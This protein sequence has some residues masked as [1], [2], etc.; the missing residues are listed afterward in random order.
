MASSDKLLV[1]LEDGVKRITFNRPERRN[2]VDTETVG[3]LH[4]AIQ[5]SA[6]DESKVVI[7]TGAGESFC[8]GADLKAIAAGRSNRTEADGNGPMGP[9]RMLLKKPVIAAVAGY[10]VAGGLELG[11]AFTELN[12]P[13]D[14]FQ[15]F[16]GQAEQRRAGDVEAHQIDYDFIEAL[17]HGMPPT[18]GLG[19]GVDRMVMLLAD[20]ASI[21]EVILFP[22][23]RT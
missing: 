4:E 7:L 10:A 17:M 8:A 16:A 9:T 6:E 1:T 12:D 23:L 15:R 14:Q 5:R 18:G 22:Q 21:R 19:V 20:Q 13:V 2:S 11:N 3:L